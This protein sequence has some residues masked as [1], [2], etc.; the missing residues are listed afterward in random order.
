MLEAIHPP[1]G[2]VGDGEDSEVS[3]GA[4]GGGLAGAWG[5]QEVGGEARQRQEASGPPHR[6]PR[7]GTV[8]KR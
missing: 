6:M 2:K 8:T 7:E 4:S 3:F 5:A 1:A